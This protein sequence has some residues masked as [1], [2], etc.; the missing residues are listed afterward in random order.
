MEQLTE[1]KNA[2]IERFKWNAY[3]Q[4]L[5]DTIRDHAKEFTFEKYKG[6]IILRGG[7]QYEL[8][9]VRAH[10]ETWRNDI[11]PN[12]ISLTLIYTIISKINSNQKKALLKAKN[13]FNSNNC[14]GPYEGK[15]KLWIQE[16]YT[17]KPE[18]IMKDQINL[19]I[20]NTK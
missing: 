11:K 5:E 17:I 20:E 12:D 14:M 19:E 13:N 18:S 15:K 16:S 1:L 10:N 8:F 4:K 3:V 9:G 7:I 6:T 2:I